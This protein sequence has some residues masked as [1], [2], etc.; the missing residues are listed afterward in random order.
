MSLPWNEQQL[1]PRRTLRCTTYCNP[2]PLPKKQKTSSISHQNV[3][4]QLT[5]NYSNP[6]FTPSQAASPNSQ[7]DRGCYKPCVRAKWLSDMLSD[8]Y[9]GGVG[10]CCPALTSRIKHD[11]FGKS[12][13]RWNHTAYVHIAS[14]FTLAEQSGASR[15]L[16]YVFMWREGGLCLM[17]LC[18]LKS[19]AVEV[20]LVSRYFVRFWLYLGISVFFCIHSLNLKRASVHPSPFNAR[21]WAVVAVGVTIPAARPTL[22]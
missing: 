13:P 9:Y 8:M 12:P 7:T 16:C 4:C 20:K 14:L 1:R 18:L 17:I 5:V 6:P 10:P 2:A 15:S 19:L 11:D 21:S 3:F 22:L